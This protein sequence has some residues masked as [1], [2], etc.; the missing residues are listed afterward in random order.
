MLIANGNTELEILPERG[1][2]IA[3]F[4]VD[5]VDIFRPLTGADTSPLA[6]SNFPL[7]PFSG[8]IASGSFGAGDIAVTLPATTWVDPLH[9]IHGDGWLA[10]WDVAENTD[11]EIRLHYDHTA[12]AWPWTYRS[13]Q[14]F[15][16]TA[17]G[18]RHGIS[19]QNL[20]DSAMPA[21][22]GLHP[23][24]PRAG[25]SIDTVFS[26]RWAVGPDRLA[27]HLEPIAADHVWF[28]DTLIDHGFDRSNAGAISVS[29]P[30]HVLTITPNADLPHTVI[31]IPPG[32]DFFCVEPVSHV[33][34]AINMPDCSHNMRWLAPQE[35]WE[36]SVEFAVE[37][38]N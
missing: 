11:T 15:Q 6:L 27:T 28:G 24:F 37:M 10:A 29:W 3:R 13:E 12:N 22:L 8:R 19:V 1:G 14:H 33:A 9:A 23:Y 21:G 25:A 4:C 5:G 16:L 26:A 30:S 35:K 7:V 18:Y 34:N 38:R 17:T 36:T 31:Y 32:E 2:G 20:S